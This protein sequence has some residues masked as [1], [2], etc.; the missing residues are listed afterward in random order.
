MNARHYSELG[1]V[2]TSAMFHQAM[3]ERFAVQIGRAHV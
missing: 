2:N 1:L 3:E